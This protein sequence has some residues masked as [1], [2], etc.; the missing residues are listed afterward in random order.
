MH[1]PNTNTYHLCIIRY[2]G[3]F[4]AMAHLLYN[5]EY[6]NLCA[7]TVVT[8]VYKFLIVRCSSFQFS[9]MLR[10]ALQG[11]LIQVGQKKSH[12]QTQL[13]RS[14]DLRAVQY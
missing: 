9:V 6:N 14:G 13:L 7:Y 8:L 3:L 2:F 5:Q 10:T 4:N 1:S 12:L 11:Q